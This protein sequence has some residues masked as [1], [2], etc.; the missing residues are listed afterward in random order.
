M[1]IINTAL[2]FKAVA[3]YIFS[4]MVQTFA[5]A[6]LLLMPRAS[7][8]RVCAINTSGFHKNAAAHTCFMKPRGASRSLAHLVAAAV[9]APALKT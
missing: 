9:A 1:I 7:P 8:R 2:N 5:C 4:F 6:L 3:F